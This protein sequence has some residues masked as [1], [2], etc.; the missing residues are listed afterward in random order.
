MKR[1]NRIWLVVV[2]LLMAVLFI[3]PIT[4]SLFRKDKEEEDV[5]ETDSWLTVISVDIQ[6]EQEAHNINLK[7]GTIKANEEV[8][9]V[10][11]NIN[12]V[13][14][15][16]L[17]YTGSLV[18]TTTEMYYAHALTP[19]NSICAVAFGETTTV[20]IDVYVE[21]NGRSYKVDSQ[22]LTVKSA[23]TKAY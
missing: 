3:A 16:D 17:E 11:V 6:W 5:Q 19:I 12:G 20:E 2:L 8:D 22:K 21:Y 18:K 15:Q 14:V 10:F 1:K 4:S 7:K 23:W 9:N 13:G